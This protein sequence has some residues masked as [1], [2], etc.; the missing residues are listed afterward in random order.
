MTNIMKRRNMIAVACGTFVLTISAIVIFGAPSASPAQTAG[1]TRAVVMELFTSQGCSSCPPADRLLSTLGR[2]QF[3]GGKVIP[4]AYHVD[5]WN[6]LGWSD[7]FSSPKWS[8]RQ[9]E[10]ARVMRSAQ[11][12]TPQLILNGTTQLVGSAN[13]AIRKEIERQLQR[14]AQGTVAIDR[15]DR[16]GSTLKVNVRAQLHQGAASREALVRVV[17]FENGVS[18][19][20]KRGENSGKQLKNDF[21]VRWGTSAFSI[22]TDQKRLAGS[23]T[24]DIPLAA[25]WRP[26]NLGVAVFIQDAQSLAIFGSS[27]RGVA[28]L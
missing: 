4:L 5:Y 24:V 15:I 3:A 7:P 25:G 23:A 17:L 16:V 18:T 26:E 14:V 28:G 8:A 22:G 21:I 1:A 20:V 12:Y 13:G 9:Q 6:H 2:D 19:A 27:V 10:Y 11:V